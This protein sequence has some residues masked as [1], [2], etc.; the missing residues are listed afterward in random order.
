MV[1]V[2][3][4]VAAKANI[5]ATFAIGQS[6]SVVTANTGSIT[7]STSSFKISN[8]GGSPADYILTNVTGA[9]S[10]PNLTT[11]PIRGLFSSDPRSSSSP[12]IF[13]TFSV[14]TPPNTVVSI[15]ASN[16]WLAADK[17]I[18]KFTQQSAG[19]ITPTTSNEGGSETINYL[20][21]F[22]GDTNTLNNL[23]AQL[24]QSANVAVTFQQVAGSPPGALSASITLN[25]P[26]TFNS[27]P[28]PGSLLLLGTGLAALG[29]LRRRRGRVDKSTFSHV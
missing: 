14:T 3:A 26:S 16:L 23:Q 12:S 13:D 6:S 20:G 28:E 7:S 17:Y 10:L 4:P 24:P 5:V 25:T 8:T 29:L 9:A 22:V 27:V 11:G 1:A 2:L 18:F 19:P 15:P 21:S